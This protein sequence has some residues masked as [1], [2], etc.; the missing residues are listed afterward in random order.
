MTETVDFEKNAGSLTGSQQQGLA[1]NAQ[2]AHMTKSSLDIHYE[3]SMLVNLPAVTAKHKNTISLHD[4]IWFCVILHDLI[5]FGLKQY[6]FSQI[7]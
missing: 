2:H 5:G 1:Q 7:P 3:E 4:C 6:D